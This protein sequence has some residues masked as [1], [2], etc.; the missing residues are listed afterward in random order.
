MQLSEDNISMTKLI[1]LTV[2]PLCTSLSLR[3]AHLIPITE[4]SHTAGEHLSSTALL[5][6]TLKRPL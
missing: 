6:S 1:E 2:R 4:L 3:G 5:C